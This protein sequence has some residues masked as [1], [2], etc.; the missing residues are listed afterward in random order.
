ML[1]KH[2]SALILKGFIH[3]VLIQFACTGT[4]RWFKNLI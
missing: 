3:Y 4:L 2:S 1:T